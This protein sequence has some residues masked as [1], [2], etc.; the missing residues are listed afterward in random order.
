MELP[1]GATLY[2]MSKVDG[3]KELIPVFRGKSAKGYMYD[4]PR[5]YFTV[6]KNMPKLMADYGAGE[7]TNMYVCKENIKYAFVDPL[8]WGHISGAVYVETNK[9]IK[10]DQI[11]DK[12]KAAELKRKNDE[13]LEESTEFDFE[14]FFSFVNENGL[15]LNEE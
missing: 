10:V 4:K 2:H 5:I 12:D 15:I 7:K 9:P 3:I 14:D 1:E 8:L 11:N 6:K 13:A